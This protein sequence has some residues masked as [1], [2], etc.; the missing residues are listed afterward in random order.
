MITALVSKV[1]ILPA[2]ED[3]KTIGDRADGLAHEEEKRVQ[4]QRGG[5]GFHR[6]FAGKY[7]QRAVDHVEAPAHQ[8]KSTRLQLASAGRRRGSRVAGRISAAP[9]IIMPLTPSRGSKRDTVRV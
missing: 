6:E 1:G 5:A 4:R 7:L 3:A 9:A 8:Q 2:C